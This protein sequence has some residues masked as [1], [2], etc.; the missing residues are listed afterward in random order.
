VLAG[1]V[2]KLS[3]L[4]DQGGEHSG[5]FLALFDRFIG[6]LR[7]DLADFFSD[8]KLSAGFAT[9]TFRKAKKPNAIQVR[10]PLEA[11][12][13]VAGNRKPR[14]CQLIPITPNQADHESSCKAPPKAEPSAS[15]PPN[16][17]ISSVT[18][19]FFLAPQPLI[20]AT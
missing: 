10:L 4:G 15:R 7:R 9:G 11:F 16:P 2:C 12:G 6:E 14:P 17:Q 20:L 13:N 3:A 1:L 8:V 18:L 19:I 5:Q